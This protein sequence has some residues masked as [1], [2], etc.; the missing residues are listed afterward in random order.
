MKNIELNIEGMKC[1]GC[2]NRLKK[3]LSM[4][5]GIDSFDISLEDKKLTLSVKREKIIGEIIKKIEA[6]GFDIA[7]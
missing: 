4:V 6:L 1:E 2:V 5:K 7:K 3:V